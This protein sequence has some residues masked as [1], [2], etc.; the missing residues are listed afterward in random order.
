[1][2]MW[3]PA[4]IEVWE[5]LQ[6]AMWR[7]WAAMPARRTKGKER[8]RPTATASSG[9]R[10]AIPTPSSRRAQAAASTSGRPGHPRG[11]CRRRRQGTAQ[12]HEGPGEAELGLEGVRD[13]QAGCLDRCELGP[14]MVIYP[15]RNLVPLPQHR[16]DVARSSSEHRVKAAGSNG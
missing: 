4:P 5:Q 3:F 6:K 12:L 1:M 14:T 7:R 2:K 9:R 10:S 13:Q 11:C 16:K 15:D 8:P